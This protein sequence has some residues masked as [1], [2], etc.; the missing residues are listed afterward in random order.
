MN[1]R[2]REVP[3]NSIRYVS[4]AG[5]GAH[6]RRR[7]SFIELDLS[8]RPRYSLY[9]FSIRP[10]RAPPPAHPGRARVLP[11]VRSGAVRSALRAGRALPKR[12]GRGFPLTWA[13]DSPLARPSLQACYTVP[14]LSDRLRSS[15]NS[16]PERNRSESVRHTAVDRHGLMVRP[17]TRTQ[18]HTRPKKAVSCN[19]MA[20][21]LPVCEV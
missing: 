20:P 5:A 18:S 21:P 16:S 8:Y 9:E 7:V 19:L 12:A 4:K 13:Q 14:R 2:L 17:T 1:E 6:A 3:R 15:P 11:S 10:A